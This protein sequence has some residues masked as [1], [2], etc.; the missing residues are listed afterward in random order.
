MPP[1]SDAPALDLAGLETWLRE[2]DEGRL[3]R[4]W[5]AADRVRAERVGDAVHL[6]GLVEISN[7]C[8]RR[9]AY[10][11]IA[12]C[13][14]PLERYRLSHDEILDGARA[15]ARL[16]FGT[17]VLQSG[18]DPGLTREF[19][20][21]VVSAI[22]GLG[23]AITLSLGERDDDDLRAW[24]EA[25]AD[26]YLLRF[27]TTD[28]ALYAAI[29]P[30]LPGQVSDR[31]AQLVR[32]RGMGY[33]VGTGVMVGIPGQTWST[34]ARDIDTFRQFDMDMIGIGPYLPS[35]RTPLAGPLGDQL[36]APE[37]EQVPN[38]ELTTL[39]AVALTRLV[40]PDTNIPGTTALSILDPDAGRRNALVR[41]ANVVMPNVTPPRYRQL[42]QIYPGKA[43]IHE[44][45]ET[46]AENVFRLVASL[47]RSVG[48]GPGGRRPTL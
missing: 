36:K 24:R 38:D 46:L 30:D 42:Y 12:A 32:M 5:E 25:G 40:C 37:G 48:E 20:A 34:L 45:V 26:R 21:R 16:G 1:R 43:A 39:K 15:A 41:G 18:E 44:S 3:E 7:Y 35:P 31:I 29:H 19:I 4:L 2:T 14:G 8:V 10:C 13:A 9:C 47:G 17:V 11:G 23:L 28:P 6:R 33:E 22:H 27:E